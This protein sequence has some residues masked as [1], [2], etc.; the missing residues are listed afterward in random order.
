MAAGRQP[1]LWDAVRAWADSAGLLLPPDSEGRDR[2]AVPREVCDSCPICQAAAT[3]ERVNPDAVSDLVDMARGVVSGLASAMASAADH[4][5]DRAQPP[6]GSSVAA[7][8]EV[9]D[10]G[11]GLDA[12]AL[13]VPDSSQA[14]PEEASAE[15]RQPAN[16]EA[17]DAGDA[18]SDD[19]AAGEDAP[20]GGAAGESGPAQSRPSPGGTEDD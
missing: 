20:G 19:T 11:A 10:A 18:D 2:P 12:A 9:H 1:N 16:A 14:D 3:A 15:D 6:D 5:D 7:D 17:P 4:R 13:H 8:A